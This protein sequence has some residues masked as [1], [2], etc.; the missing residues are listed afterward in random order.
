MTPLAGGGELD[1]LVGLIKDRSTDAEV[2]DD[3]ATDILREVSLILGKTDAEVN[4]F[5]RLPE[6][7]RT[8]RVKK[9]LQ[10][11][12]YRK[13]KMNRS[14]GRAMERLLYRRIKDALWNKYKCTLGESLNGHA[15]P[16]TLGE[17]ITH[18]AKAR[19]ES[20]SKPLQSPDWYNHTTHHIKVSH[21]ANTGVFE[22][23][24]PTV[25]FEGEVMELTTTE[26]DNDSRYGHSV[27]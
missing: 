7:E 15:Q 8:E 9:A 25:N 23:L 10:D 14:E 16:D 2:D 20:L 4:Q 13:Y 5:T 22:G 6:K 18:K 1:D 21:K 12:I 26:S 19:N 24:P 11:V 17:S 3:R 27:E